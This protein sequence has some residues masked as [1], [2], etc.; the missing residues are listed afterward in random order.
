[1]Q[2][3]LNLSAPTHQKGLWFGLLDFFDIPGTVPWGR[4]DSGVNTGVKTVVDR[5][6]DIRDD[7][8]EVLELPQD[9]VVV[10]VPSRARP[11]RKLAH[12]LQARHR[13]RADPCRNDPMRMGPRRAANQLHSALVA[14]HHT[15]LPTCCRMVSLICWGLE[16]LLLAVLVAVLGHRV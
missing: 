6:G 8:G 2:F 11:A 5:K 3:R 4:V 14:V 12:G 15:P 16:V 1:M 9:K 13:W 7:F 10:Q